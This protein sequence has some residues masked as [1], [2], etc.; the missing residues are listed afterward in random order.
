VSNLDIS[1]FKVLVIEDNSFVRQILTQVLRGLH[2]MDIVEAT[3]G[4]D[5]LEKL[6]MYEPDLILVDWEMQPLNGIEFI[7]IIRAGEDFDDRYIPIIMVTGHSEQHRIIQ[8]RDAGIT[9]MLVK[10]VSAE[11]LYRRI[12]SVIERPRT[13][14]EAESYFGPDRRRRV[15]H[16]ADERRHEEIEIS[17][18]DD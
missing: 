17:L 3:D 11:K 14:V 5:A 1:A 10:P 15:Q 12:K 16:V 9:E 18:E 13:F 7:K 8:A 6:K 4:A 2:I